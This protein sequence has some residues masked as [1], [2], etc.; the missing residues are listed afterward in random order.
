[1]FLDCLWSL[2]PLDIADQNQGGIA[3]VNTSS[4]SSGTLNNFPIAFNNDYP[5]LVAIPNGDATSSAS[6]HVSTQIKTTDRSSFK[7]AISIGTGW[8]TMSAKYIA[9]GF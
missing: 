3:Y 6:N 9:M 1:M 2:N 5:S 8:T 4:G 7:I